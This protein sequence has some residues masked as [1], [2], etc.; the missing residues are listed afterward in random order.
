MVCVILRKDL[1]QLLCT[2]TICIVRK[3]NDM[4]KKKVT[5]YCGNGK[6]KTAAAFGYAIQSA[7]QGRNSII[8]QF[9]KGKKEKETEQLLSRLEPEV[10][11]FSFA[12]FE[13]DFSELSSEEQ[14][15]ES[16]NIRNGFNFAR[17]V[18][19]TGECNLLILDSFLELL[20]NGMISAEELDN[21]MNASSEDTEI[22][23]T[24]KH[25]NDALRKY[26][27]KIYEIHAD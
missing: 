8:I 24:G 12:R 3:E 27:E 10:K 20:D 21:L 26:A 16:M 4:C 11:F 18:L 5:V 2:V 6:G 15:E 17:K 14:Q 9:M 1:E 22:L 23:F 25:M 13:K 7:G 19:V